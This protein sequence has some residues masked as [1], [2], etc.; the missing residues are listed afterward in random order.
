MARRSPTVGSAAGAPGGGDSAG[1]QASRRCII[2][3][4]GT[5]TALL[6]TRKLSPARVQHG[7]TAGSPVR[8][9]H[10]RA[11]PVRLLSRCRNSGS[12]FAATVWAPLSRGLLSAAGALVLQTGLDQDCDAGGLHSTR[13]GQPAAADAPGKISHTARQS[14][15]PPYPPG[16]AAVEGP[17]PAGSAACGSRLQPTFHK[18]VQTAIRQQGAQRV[19]AR[20]PAA[21]QGG[22]LPGGRHTS[23][24]AWAPSA[25]PIA[26]RC[27]RCRGGSTEGSEACQPLRRACIIPCAAAGSGDRRRRRRWRR[28]RRRD[29]QGGRYQAAPHPWQA[30]AML[31]L[32]REAEQSGFQTSVGVSWLAA[33]WPGAGP[34]T[35]SQQTL[36]AHNRIPR[37]Q[38]SAELLNRPA[39]SLHGS[40]VSALCA[41]ALPR[42]PIPFLGWLG[43]PATARLGVR[44]LGSLHTGRRCSVPPVATRR[45]LPPSPSPPSPL[46]RSSPLHQPACVC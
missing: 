46:L 44:R 22:A 36:A 38:N 23:L 3:D 26:T 17:P 25:Q 9:S 30:G 40:W 15:V 1:G 20:P 8:L 21:V 37:S 2:D 35:L 18:T 12:A 5:F 29:A 28:R 14:R 27:L 13:G 11:P 19:S 41:R 4:A 34:R 43:G 7:A 39:T 45:R 42:A 31:Y 16:A 32:G 6:R 24:A 33:A 10:A